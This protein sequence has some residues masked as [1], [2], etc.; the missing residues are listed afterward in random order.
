MDCLLKEE[1]SVV[2]TGGSLRKVRISD[3][4]GIL[5]HKELKTHKIGGQ[6]LPTGE[7]VFYIRLTTKGGAHVDVPRGIADNDAELLDLCL[8][9][10]CPSSLKA[11]LER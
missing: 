11:L 2:D 4:Q 7:S 1:I 5:P 6:V 8:S 9:V 10:L 3:I